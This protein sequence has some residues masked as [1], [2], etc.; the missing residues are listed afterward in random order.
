MKDSIS[1]KDVLLT[2]PTSGLCEVDIEK[3]INLWNNR[4][5]SISQWREEYSLV[6]VYDFN[7][8][9]KCNISKEQAHEL[10]GKLNLVDE[11][12]SIFRSGRTWR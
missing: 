2:F 7:N 1:I 9:G 5:W 8:Y 10:I 3:C 4:F 6:K 12:S 11:Q